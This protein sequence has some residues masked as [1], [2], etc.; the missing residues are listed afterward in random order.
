M[1]AALGVFAA[2]CS[3]WKDGACESNWAGDAHW[4][5]LPVLVLAVLP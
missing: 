2:P 3:N 5:L 1:L 4:L